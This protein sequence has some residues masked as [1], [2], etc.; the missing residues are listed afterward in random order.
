MEEACLCVCLCLCL[1][2]CVCLCLFVCVKEREG[3]SQSFIQ[4]C[5][6]HLFSFWGVHSTD[7]NES[8]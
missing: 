8:S 4:S 6:G 2:V 1:C 3:D 5:P 7:Q